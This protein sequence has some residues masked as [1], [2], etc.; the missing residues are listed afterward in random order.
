MEDFP[1]WLIWLV[2]KMDCILQVD[3]LHHLDH[4]RKTDVW[5]LKT[6]SSKTDVLLPG[7]HFDF[8]LWLCFHSLES[9][10]ACWY[11]DHEWRCFLFK[12]REYP[13]A[14]FAY[15]PSMLHPHT[16]HIFPRVFHVIPMG[17]LPSQVSHPTIQ[18][19]RSHKH[20]KCQRCASRD[21]KKKNIA[22]LEI[23]PFIG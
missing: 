11:M 18:A 5:N 1:I 21:E 7:V 23:H 13:P 17:E 9:N 15:P 6:M 8:I 12:R 3:W 10:R 2:G 19:F 14:M 20:R 22:W 4:P 16:Y